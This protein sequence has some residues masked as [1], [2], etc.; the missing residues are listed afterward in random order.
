M[1]CVLCFRKLVRHR[2]REKAHRVMSVSLERF[3]QELWT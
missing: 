2:W 1:V 3:G